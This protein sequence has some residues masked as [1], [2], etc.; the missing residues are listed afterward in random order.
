MV[1]LLPPLLTALAVGNSK[2]KRTTAH[3]LTIQGYTIALW[4]RKK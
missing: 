2:H 4:V 1:A 3:K